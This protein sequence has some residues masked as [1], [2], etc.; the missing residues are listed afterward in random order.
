MNIKCIATDLY[1]RIKSE[2]YGTAYVMRLLSSWIFVCLVNYLKKQKIFF[3]EYA[4]DINI[5]FFLLSVIGVYLLFTA[6][7]FLPALKKYKTDSVILLAVTSVTCCMMSLAYF[8]ENDK[9]IGAFVAFAPIIALCVWYTVGKQKLKA[10]RCAAYITPLLIIAGCAVMLLFTVVATAS[11]YYGLNAPA[12]D[13]GIFTQMFENMK[14]GLGPVTTLERNYL[15][16][17]FSVHF[18]PA[19]YLLLPFYV[20]IPHP[21]TLQMLQGALIVSGVI[22]VMLICRNYSFTPFK[23]ALV[24]ITYT[25]YPAFIGGC[26]YDIHENCMLLPFLLWLFYAIETENIP[27]TAVFSVLTLLVKEDAAVY[28]AVVGLYLIFSDRSR[29]MRIT[30]IA[31]VFCSVAYFLLVC[32]YLESNGLGVMTWRY[33]NY[34]YDADGG[35]ISV[36]MA[37]ILNPAFV[38]S[39]LLTGEKA[40]Y[41]LQM[42][43][44][45][46]FMPVITKRFH[47]YILLI[48]FILVNLMPDYQYQH[49]IYFQYSFG[50]GALLFW[51]FIMN[52][53]DIKYEQRKCV[54]AFSVVASAVMLT[55]TVTGMLTNIEYAEEPHNQRIVSYLENIPVTGESI[56]TDTFFAPQLYKHKE[57][58]VI[59]AHKAADEKNTPLSQIVLLDKNLPRYEQNYSFFVEHGYIEVPLDDSLSTRITRLIRSDNI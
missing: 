59:P 12:F 20:L 17:H 38:L 46:G 25:L 56:T 57:L 22:P 28:V 33:K 9:G 6:I 4:A 29:K 14:D 49:S 7:R 41:A 2:N 37:V 39:N 27:L 52:L 31:V 19:Y 8:R 30:G 54:T 11:R 3:K 23:T 55:S 18:S 21:V 13:F 34:M 43:A 35:L 26:S 44:T 1:N 5:P 24:C 53:R 48:P 40:V 32:H 16:S 42:V 47:R 50:T 15:L 10:G 51:L 58:Y 36:I 45:L